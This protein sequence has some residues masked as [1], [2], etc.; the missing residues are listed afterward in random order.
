MPDGEGVFCWEIERSRGWSAEFCNY[1]A[2]NSDSFSDMGAFEANPAH[3]S[4][5][6]VKVLSIT[7]TS[8]AAALH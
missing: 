6:I 1:K 8:P 7:K 3:G 4:G 2:P 5:R